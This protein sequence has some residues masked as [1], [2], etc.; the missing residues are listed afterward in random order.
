MKFHYGLSNNL[1]WMTLKLAG[2]EKRVQI[3]EAQ[4]MKTNAPGNSPE[5][6]SPP[7]PF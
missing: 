1:W 3:L 4:Q 2:L 5:P 6:G 7:N